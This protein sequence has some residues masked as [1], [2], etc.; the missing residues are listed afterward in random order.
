[1]PNWSGLILTQQG[2]QLQAKVEAGTKLVI[3]KLKLGSGVLPEGKQMEELRDLV[4]PKQNVGIAT[5]EAQNDGTCKLSAT[6]SNTGLAAGYYVREL[7]VFATDPD[8]GEVLY[9]VANDSAPDYLPAEGGATVV[10]QEFAVYVSANNTDNVVA[11]IDAGA[12]ATMGYVQLSIKNH[13]DDIDAHSAAIGKH[14]SAASVHT[15]NLASKAEA[16]AGT[17][18][19]KFMTPARDREAMQAFVGGDLTGMI[20]AFAGSTIPSGFLL[21]DGSKVSRTTY[22][23]LF[24]VIGTTYGAGDGSTTFTLPNL[25]DRFIEGS[26]AAGSYRAAG[27]PNIAGYFECRGID[28]QNLTLVWGDNNLFKQSKLAGNTSV[29]KANQV[30]SNT[31][32][33]AMWR[34]EF[35]AKACND[36][37]GNSITVQPAACTIKFL[38]KY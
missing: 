25:I 11:E 23:K 18:T 8:K 7:G 33:E 1:M 9:L 20:F 36:L 37:Y 38:L 5:I 19:S 31:N 13:N 28:Y 32:Y 15:A 10:S 26:S 14:N 12:L 2:R 4:T 29:E 30:N 22:K 24:N 16:E 3:T 17:N 34:V 21:C 27:L 6:I 35:D